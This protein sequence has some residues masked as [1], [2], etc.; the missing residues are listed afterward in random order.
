MSVLI[1]AT[2]LLAAASGAGVV[3]ARTP[4]RQIF[5]MGANG[6]VLSL[7]FMALQAPDVA[8][9]ELIIG[10]AALPLLFFVV[11]ARTRMDRTPAAAPAEKST[12]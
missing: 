3:F 10:T 11:L 12:P 4:Q 9:A 8:F 6:L 5:A 2:L 7:L 1:I